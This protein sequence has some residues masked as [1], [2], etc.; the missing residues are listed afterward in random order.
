MLG[1]KARE[2]LQSLNVKIY[3][4]SADLNS[5]AQL[6]QY[7]FVKGVTTN[8]TLMKKAGVTDYEWFARKALEL[9]KALPISFEVFA[10]DLASMEAQAAYIATWGKNVNVKIP[11]TNTKGEF[12]GPII[13]RLAARGVKVNVTAIMTIEQIKQLLPCFSKD[14][15]AILSVFAGRIA[16]TGVDPLPLLK[17]I[18]PLLQAHPNIELLWASTREVLN[19]FHAESAGCDIITVGPEFLKKLDI[20]GKDLESFSLETVL[21]FFNDASAAGYTI[22]IPVLEVCDN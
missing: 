11:V 16:D 20:L 5:I 7:D 22:K 21:M 17:S 14:A 4:D 15:S 18:K 1:V 2:I 8:P 9:V 12:C 10:D 3:S 6:S 19:I 13:K